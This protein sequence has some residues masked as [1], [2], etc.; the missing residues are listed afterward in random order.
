MLASAAA[1]AVGI[2]VAV[3]TVPLYSGGS[4]SGT[5]S[6]TGDRTFTTTIT[7]SHA[8]LVQVNGPRILIPIAVPV[9]AVAL[10]AAAL[11]HRRRAGKAGPGL[12][13]TTVLLLLGAGT[14]VAMLSIGVFVLPVDALLLAACLRA[15]SM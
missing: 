7:S 3:L 8:T 13:A 10:V 9:L 11:S 2:V 12:V 4:I 5:T 15:S 1:W 6:A 14:L